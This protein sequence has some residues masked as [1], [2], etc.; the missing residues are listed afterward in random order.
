MLKLYAN[1][2][3]TVIII[4]LYE[5]VIMHHGMQSF[6][7]IVYCT[8][9]YCTLVYCTLAD[10]SDCFAT[11]ISIRE[12]ANKPYARKTF[13]EINNFIE[14]YNNSVI[15]FIQCFGTSLLGWITSQAR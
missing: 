11:S 13:N 5:I 4:Y 15:E 3:N 14:A 2:D 9:V 6:H 7:I 1:H 12:H 10:R 8:P